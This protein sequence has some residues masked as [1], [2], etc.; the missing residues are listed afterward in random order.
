MLFTSPQLTIQKENRN[1]H[2][3]LKF[4]FKG[5]LTKTASTLGAQ[6]WSEEMLFHS[7][8]AYEFIWDCSRMTGFEPAART[9]WYK[10]ISLH[11]RQISQVNTIS[12]SIMIRSAAK[13]MLQFF[14]IPNVAQRSMPAKAE[15]IQAAAP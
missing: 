13:V 15:R 5:K 6:A 12:D 8:M 7:H 2:I 9:E 14:G 4:V 3:L 1:D 11:K 10:R